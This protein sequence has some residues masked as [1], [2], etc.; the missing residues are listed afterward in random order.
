LDIFFKGM[1]G[2]GV[3]T[4]YCWGNQG[5]YFILLQ[6][7]LLIT[8]MGLIN[9]FA[10]RATARVAPTNRIIMFFYAFGCCAKLRNINAKSGK[11]CPYK[12]VSLCC[13]AYRV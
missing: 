4:Y 6:G 5:V 9:H 1:G 11:P 10:F 7:R 2:A 3:F 13:L 8:A 12:S